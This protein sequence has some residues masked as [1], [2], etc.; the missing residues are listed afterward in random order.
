MSPWIAHKKLIDNFLSLSYLQLVTYLLPLVSVPYLVRVLGPERFGLIILAQALSQYM[1]ILID[2]GFG[3]SATRSIAIHHSQPTRVAEIH[4]SVLFIKAFLTL[5]SMGLLVLIVIAIPKFRSEWLLFLLSF[6]VVVGNTLLPSWLFQG[7]EDMKP[8]AYLNV[9]S[10]GLFLIA[11]FLVVKSSDDYWVVPLVNG[12]GALL[13]AVIGLWFGSRRFGLILRLPSK[14][15]LLRELKEGWHLFISTVAI[16]M[17]SVSNPLILG[18]FASNAQ[19]GYFS[20]AEKLIRGLMGL[21]LIP[22]SRTLYPH[23]SQL[24]TVSKTQATQLLRN[25]LK[26]LSLFSLAAS[27]A[28]FLFAEPL[29]EWSLGSAFRGAVFPLK[30]LSPMP[31]IMTL[32]NVFG[33]QALVAFGKKEV[34]SRILLAGSVL[35]LTLGIGLSYI[36]QETGMAVCWLVTELCVAMGMGL[37]LAVKEPEIFSATRA[38]TNEINLETLSTVHSPRPIVKACPSRLQ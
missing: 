24:A 38:N 26:G 18:I 1:A 16:S 37:Y 7:M 33:V 30:I 19:V 2:Y 34:F 29:V 8:L 23:I 36:Y 5:I 10:R 22:T 27:L 31:I 13:A 32:S 17:Y 35:S 20:G 28:L 15:S 9:I 14:D 12:C 25:I 21:L 3:Y 11:L 6:G 4:S